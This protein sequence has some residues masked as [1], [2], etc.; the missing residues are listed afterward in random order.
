MN[1]HAIWSAFHSLFDPVSLQHAIQAWGW[2]AYP[3]LF[4][5]I[6]AETGLLVGFFFPGDSLLFIAGFVC[7][8]A[9]GKGLN[10]WYLAPVLMLAAIIGDTC[11]YLLGL[12]TGPLIFHREDSLLFHKKHL[13]RT[14]EF[15][16]RHGGKTIIY[17]RFVPIVRTFAPFVAGVGK[18]D[19]RRFLSFN[20]WGGIGWVFIIMLLGYFLGNIPIVK[21]NLEKAVLLV[22]FLSFVPIMLEAFRARRERKSDGK[23]KGNSTVQPE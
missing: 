8:I 17:A 21:K 13:Q 5:V 3:V 19:Y 16:E 11:G 6:F 12:K 14:H 23:V 9:E 1:L 10:I 2:V 18:M 15:Y 4:A 22:I 7:S 20:V